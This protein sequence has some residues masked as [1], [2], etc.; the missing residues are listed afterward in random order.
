MIIMQPC[1]AGMLRGATACRLP[2]PSTRRAPDGV[3]AVPQRV[4][5]NVNVSLL[6]PEPAERFGG[7]SLLRQ[8]DVAHVPRCF[9]IAIAS[10]YRR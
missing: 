6:V 9:R 3:T 10:G 2:V 7:F 8:S 5:E 1:R 4:H